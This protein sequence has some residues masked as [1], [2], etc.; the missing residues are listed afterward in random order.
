[1]KICSR[2]TVFAGIT[3]A[4][5]SSISR[6][7]SIQHDGWIDLNKNGKMDVYEDVSQPIDV[8]VEDLL[9]QMTTEEKTMQLVT[10]YGWKRVLQDPLPTPEWDNEI[11]KDGLGNIDEH[12]NGNRYQ[13][14]DWPPSSH[15]ETPQRRP[16][17][18][19]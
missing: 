4:L 17:L 5:T 11:W 16:A 2:M 18:V 19:Y 14:L 13:G 10:L 3:L 9:S 6:A 15:V 12:I 7:Q 8:R 1:M